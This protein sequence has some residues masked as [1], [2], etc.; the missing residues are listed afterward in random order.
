[1][2]FEKKRLAV[3]L[4]AQLE[5]TSLCN[6]RCIHCYNLDS[7]EE[8]RPIQQVSDETIIACAQ[9]LIESKIFGVIITGG[10]P[11]IK[12]ELTKRV[13]TLF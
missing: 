6:H 2:F 13:I 4:T 10:E 7:N 9:K 5:I 1:M 11:L 3:P 8:N 12:K